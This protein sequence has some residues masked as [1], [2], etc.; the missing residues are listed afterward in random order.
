M[1]CRIWA[2]MIL[3][4][5]VVLGIASL[6][7]GQ[8]EGGSNP[9]NGAA[10][11][12]GDKLVRG[13]EGLVVVKVGIRSPY[14]I[15]SVKPHDPLLIPTSVMV[16]LPAGMEADSVKYPVAHEIPAPGGVGV[17]GGFG[18]VGIGAQTLS[19][20]TGTVYIEV[21]VKVA[22]DAPLGAAAM[23]V[24][25]TTQA[26]TTVCLPPKHQKIVVPVVI[27]EAGSVVGAT[28]A[29]LMAEAGTQQYVT[30]PI[31]S[32]ATVPVTAA[33]VSRQGDRG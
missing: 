22:G 15:Q 10:I 4:V 23:E 18:A 19:V 21:P 20:Y 30:L 24:T 13:G 28:D 8:T 5:G 7:R 3:W 16:K 6:A 31:Q 32:A 29:A 26:C 17:G 14:H 1:K 27:A 11:L 9:V 2:V 25:L 33:A 12:S